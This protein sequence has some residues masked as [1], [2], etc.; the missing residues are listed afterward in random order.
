MNTA[1]IILVAIVVICAALLG[2][3]SWKRR[4]Y[5]KA[6]E[7]RIKKADPPSSRSK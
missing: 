4:R 1:V 2:Y 5:A 6:V 3:D 7:R